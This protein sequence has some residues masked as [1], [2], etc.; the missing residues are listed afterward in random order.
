MRVRP[1]P[2]PRAGGPDL[3]E[4]LLVAL[5]V[6]L[7]ATAG[8]AS[9]AIADPTLAARWC[10][11]ACRDASGGQ[12]PVIVVGR[13]GAAAESMAEAL[14]VEWAPI[15]AHRVWKDSVRFETFGF[16]T[17]GSCAGLYG[18]LQCPMDAPSQDAVVLLPPLRATATGTEPPNPIL[19]VG[20]RTTGLG[21]V[22][23]TTQCEKRT[24]RV[25]E[26]RPVGP[27]K[28]FKM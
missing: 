10:A 24:T 15:A 6:P 13:A 28:R 2:L 20:G 21:H 5:R 1:L 14:S 18:P 19:F 7:G 9:G 11:R 26:N 27:D 8:S 23:A 17:V 4:F 3:S 16:W 12:G 25:E 22:R